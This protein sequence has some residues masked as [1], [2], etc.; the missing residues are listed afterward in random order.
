MTATV[1]VTPNERMALHPTLE[2]DTEA[3]SAIH[4]DGIDVPL[5]IANDE[6]P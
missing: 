4:V 2:A 3:H 1:L 5:G 6:G